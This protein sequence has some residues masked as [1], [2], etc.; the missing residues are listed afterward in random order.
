MRHEGRVYDKTLHVSLEKVTV[1]RM[2]S[3]LFTVLRE[4]RMTTVFQ[5]RING[6]CPLISRVAVWFR[7]CAR[8]VKECNEQFFSVFS[9]VWVNSSVYNDEI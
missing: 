5:N 4:M 8:F 7:E 3:V 1:M 6:F 2:F 9:V